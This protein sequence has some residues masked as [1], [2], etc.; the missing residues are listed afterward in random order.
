MKKKKKK[1]KKEKK[2]QRKKTKLSKYKT[3]A[4]ETNKLEMITSQPASQSQP[5]SELNSIKSKTVTI[6]YS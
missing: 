6:V 5:S 1:M 3:A 2:K 4:D